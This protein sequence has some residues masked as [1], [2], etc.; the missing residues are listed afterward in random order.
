M[1]ALEREP[2][3]SA[4]RRRPQRR[5][6]DARPKSPLIASSTRTPSGDQKMFNVFAFLILAGAALAAFNLATQDRRSAAAR[7]R[8][9]DGARASRR[10]SW[11][12]GRCCSGSRSR[13]SERSSALLLGL[14]MGEIFRGV[15]EDLLPLP[16]MRTPFEP[17]VFA[18]AAIVGFFLPIIA[19]AIPVW[20]GLRQTPARG[21]PGRISV[22]SGKRPRRTG[23]ASA[24]A[25]FER[26]PDAAPKRFARAS[27]NAPDGAR[28]R[29]CAQCAR[30][31]PWTD[32]LVQCDGRSQR[33]RDRPGQSEAEW[34]SPSMAS[35]S[36]SAA[37]KIVASAPGVAAAEPQLTLPATFSAL[38]QRHSTAASRC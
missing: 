9:R 23:Q 26:R 12:S 19:T 31:L 17:A 20:R 29:R 4:R 37:R 35:E 32:R 25:G 33:S 3:A 30:C 24:A 16:E 10:D 34:S 22:R 27:P 1:P 13:S 2:G 14:V 5:S 28:D 36:S 8:H 18:R 21:D 11:R 7:D 6:H 15:L 38:G